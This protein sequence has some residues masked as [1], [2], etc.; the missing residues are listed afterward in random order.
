MVWLICQEHLKT[1]IPTTT[2]GLF[3]VIAGHSLQVRLLVWDSYSGK[4]LKNEEDHSLIAFRLREIPRLC[5][6]EG[7]IKIT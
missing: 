4:N 7:L 3:Q 5:R 1:M 2:M 6:D